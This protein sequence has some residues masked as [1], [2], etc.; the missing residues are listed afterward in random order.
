[1]EGPWS[2]LIPVIGTVLAAVI[3]GAAQLINSRNDRAQA[4]QEVDLL[5]K[6]DPTSDT[7]KQLNQ[8]VEARV[9]QWHA[10]F[11]KN[12]PPPPLVGQRRRTYRVIAVAGR[13]LIATAVV[14]AVVLILLWVAIALVA[15]FSA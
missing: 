7:A 9:Q 15:A 5:L 12:T 10:K 14:I 11:Y 4:H 1:M 13:I 6:L 8:V 2:L 3:A